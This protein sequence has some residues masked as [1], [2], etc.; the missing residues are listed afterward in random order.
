[1]HIEVARMILNGHQ[2]V[3]VVS[4]IASSAQIGSCLP[5]AVLVGGNAYMQGTDELTESERAVIPQQPGP[6]F[7]V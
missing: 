1:M 3:K 6:V 2:T 4:V 7:C 5:S